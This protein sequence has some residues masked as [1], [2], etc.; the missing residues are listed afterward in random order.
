MSKRAILLLL[1]IILPLSAISC[2][3]PPEMPRTNLIISTLCDT[4]ISLPA[5]K[6]YSSDLNPTDK[7]HLSDRLISAYLG[8]PDI[9]KYKKDWVSYSIFVPSG[10]HPCEFAAIYCSTPEALIDTSRLLT[11]R[12]DSVKR[13]YGNEFQGY[14]DNAK[15]INIGNFAIL[16]ISSDTATALK[17]VRKVCR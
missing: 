12:I 5:G 16:I 3:N 7:N 11:S 2:S 4:E 13:Q 15:V 8:E 9:E 1:I 6:I 17:A 10:S 14:T